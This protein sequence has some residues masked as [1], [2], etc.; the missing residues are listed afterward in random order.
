MQTTPAGYSEERCG[1]LL[2][3]PERISGFIPGTSLESPDGF[4]LLPGELLRAEREARLEGCQVVGVYHSH[5]S[6]NLAPS[7][8]DHAGAVNS[9]LYLILGAAEFKLYRR[10]AQA[11]R[12]QPWLEVA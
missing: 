8:K 12:P 7:W 2:G 5:P 10:S 6:G 4:V 3:Q 9:W 1:F 11:F